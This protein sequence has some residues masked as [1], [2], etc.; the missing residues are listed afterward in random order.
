MIE[1]TETF[2]DGRTHTIQLSSDILGDQWMLDRYLECRSQIKELGLEQAM[3]KWHND[4]AK[5]RRKLGLKVKDR[6]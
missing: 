5:E 3:Q 1:H 4:E 2:P 6:Y